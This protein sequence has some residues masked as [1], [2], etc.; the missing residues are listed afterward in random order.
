[1]ESQHGRLHTGMAT[2]G[3]AL[4][5]DSPYYVVR[6]TDQEF[7]KAVARRDS[8]VLIKGAR[9]MGKTSLMARGLQQ[10]R[11]N[12]A[13]VVLTD[14]QALSA[15]HLASVESLFLMLAEAITDQ[16]DLN[17]SPADVWHERRGA[18][19]NLERLLRRNVLESLSQQVV[20]GL[21]EVD[22]LFTCD[23]GSEVFG[24]FRSWH[25][26]RS[27]EPESPW[28]QLTLVITYATEAHLFISD[29][30]QS[31]FNV[32]TRLTMQD[33][34]LE[35]VA[36]LN[37][38]YNRPLRSPEETARFYMLVGGQPYLTQQGLMEMSARGQTLPALEAAENLEEGPFGDHLRRVLVTLSQDPAMVEAA[39]ALLRGGLCPNRES[40][41]R[42]RSGGLLAGKSASEARFRCQ[43]YEIYLARR[44]L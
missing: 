20:W 43:L 39:R 15:R 2:T 33:F 35:E 44:L 40:F 12:G 34:T 18:N 21:D 7:Q 36:T 5:V 16:L 19:T 42:L 8:I 4:P 37:A 26:R 13:R 28:S 17:I 30:N 23:F 25:N 24:L 31:P 10:A 41:Y 1:M 29:L 27:L 38:R 9:Q 6:P 11:E 22:R 32:G 3:G 14:F